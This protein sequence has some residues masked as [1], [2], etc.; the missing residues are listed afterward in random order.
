M[1]TVYGTKY[2][3]GSNLT[4]NYELIPEKNVRK[5][6]ILL[7]LKNAVLWDVTPCGSCR[8]RHFQGM[9]VLTNPT[10][11]NI[12]EDGILHSQCLK[13]L[14]SYLMFMVMKC[15]TWKAYIMKHII[16]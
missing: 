7:L 9:S 16:T 1:F 4:M 5:F 10:R 15:N 2:T 12:P 14:K 13:N 8:N 3:E 11:R 6:Q